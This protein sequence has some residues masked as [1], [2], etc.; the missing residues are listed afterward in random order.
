M[1]PFELI[2]RRYSPRRL[3]VLAAAVAA[4]AVAAAATAAFAVPAATGGHHASAA[5]AARA[6]AG[7]A[8]K[9]LVEHTVKFMTNQPVGTGIPVNPGYM[10]A[11]LDELYDF[12]GNQHVATA[13]GDLDLLYAR[14]DGHVVQYI[15]EQMHF[16]DGTLVGTGTQDRTSVIA[17][18]WVSM[19]IRG[20][21]GRYAG[22]SGT[23][24]WRVISK[25]DPT[26][27]VEDEITL[28]RKH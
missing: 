24:R 23:W 15:A 28:C 1:R 5:D 17:Q 2:G 14:P 21:S 22:M 19:A 16:S 6:K 13:A 25:T 8:R 27:P 3:A 11:Y 4:A 9:H 26:Y 18:D 12:T 20:T 7:C 10:S